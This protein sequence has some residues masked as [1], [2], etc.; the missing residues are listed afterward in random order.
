M[1]R[2]IY[3]NDVHLS[4]NS[5]INLANWNS[6]ESFE[7]NGSC[8]KIHILMGNTE[9]KWAFQWVTEVEK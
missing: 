6:S 7:I 9:N 4:S 8:Y 1:V 2:D 3:N 5:D